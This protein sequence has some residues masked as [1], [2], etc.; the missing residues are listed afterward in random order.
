MSGSM[1]CP[2][3]KGKVP[4]SS[5]R[6]PLCGHELKEWTPTSLD[7]GSTTSRLVAKDYGTTIRSSGMVKTFIGIALVIIGVAI[8]L[9]VGGKGPRKLLATTPGLGVVMLLVGVFEWVTGKRVTDVEKMSDGQQL[10]IKS[11]V[12]LLM[13]VCFSAFSFVLPNLLK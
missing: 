1:A 13:V 4:T 12:I 5:R 11:G 3:C 2:A 8:V 10:V 9:L 6:C 7:P